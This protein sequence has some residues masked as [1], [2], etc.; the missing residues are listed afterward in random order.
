MRCSFKS[1]LIDK[2]K[3][4]KS[5]IAEPIFENYSESVEQKSDLAT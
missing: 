5:V 3:E 2:S 4:C 1:Y